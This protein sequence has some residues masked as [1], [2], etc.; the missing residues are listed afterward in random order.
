MK[1]ERFPEGSEFPRSRLELVVVR[2]ETMQRFQA[3]TAGVRSGLG[4]WQLQG[5]TLQFRL[6]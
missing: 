6:P 2:L 4:R 1:P 3:P 5:L